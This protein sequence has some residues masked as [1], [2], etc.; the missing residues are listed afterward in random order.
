[1]MQKF[2]T[3][4]AADWFAISIRWIMLVG[5]ILS[6]GLAQKI[7]VVSMWPLGIMIL[8]NILMTALASLN[9]RI[10]YLRQINVLVDLVLAGVFFLVQGGLRGP[11]FWIGLLPILTGS[12]YFAFLG[13]LILHYYFP[14][15]FLYRTKSV[16]NFSCCYYGML[17]GLSLL[18]GLLGRR[19]M[20]Q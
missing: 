20:L 6:L 4:Y 13:A 15:W 9:V 3:P 16:E 18:F 5:L 12:I 17:T 2:E 14:V 8:W 1:M 10:T 19:M 11:G 7:E